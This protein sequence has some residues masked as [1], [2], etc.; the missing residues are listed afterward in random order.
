MNHGLKLTI[1]VKVLI[2]TILLLKNQIK[3]IHNFLSIDGWPDGEAKQHNK[4]VSQSIC[5]LGV[6]QLGK[7]ITNSEFCLQ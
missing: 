2:L 7:V 4:S 6:K 1:Y 5:Q 3:V